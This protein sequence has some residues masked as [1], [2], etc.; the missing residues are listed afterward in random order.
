MD[1]LHCLYA[2]SLKLHALLCI[3]ASEVEATP[4]KRDEVMFPQLDG[5]QRSHFNGDV[6]KVKGKIH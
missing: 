2:M 1:E 4:V 3:L 6:I 5:S